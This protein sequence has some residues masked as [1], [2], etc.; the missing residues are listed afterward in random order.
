MEHGSVLETIHKFFKYLTL[1][2][3]IKSLVEVSVSPAMKIEKKYR[4]G[5][6]ILVYFSLLSV[7]M[8]IVFCA[9]QAFYVCSGCGKNIQFV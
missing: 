1:L 4:I 2:V 8:E 9:V 7:A 3:E 5:N 6:H